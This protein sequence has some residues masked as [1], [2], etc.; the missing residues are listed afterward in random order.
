VFGVVHRR[1]EN[2]EEAED[3]V[4]KAILRTTDSL[5]EIDKTCLGSVTESG[6]KKP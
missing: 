6:R 4:Q 3:I 1:A 2:I 5:A